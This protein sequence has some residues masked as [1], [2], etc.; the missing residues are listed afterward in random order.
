MFSKKI[1][2]FFFLLGTIVVAVSIPFSPFLLSLGQFILAGNWLAEFDFKRK[3]QVFKKRDSIIFFIS[4]FLVHLIWLLNTSNLQYALHDLK[5]KLP[6]FILPIIFGTTKALTRAEFKIILHFFLASIFVSTVYSFF[7]F[8]GITPVHATDNRNLSPFISHIRYALVITLSIY[9]L[10]SFLICNKYFKYIPSIYYIAILI[11]LV[12]FVLFLGAY[13]GSV[14]LCVIAPFALFFWLKNIKERKKKKLGIS[15]IISILILIFG[16]FTLSVIRYTNRNEIN[17]DSLDVYT[18]NGNKYNHFPNMKDYENHDLVWM[19]ICEKELGKEWNKLSEYKFEGVDKKGQPIK[20][21][22]FRYLTSKGFRK[23]S[24]GISHLTKKD[25]D[26]IQN[27]YSNYLF[28]N[29]LALYPRLYQIFWEIENYH[30]YGNPSGHSLTQRI[31]YV[32]NACRV[33]KRHFWFGAGT[34]D[35]DDEIKLQY[36]YDKS[37]LDEKWQLRAHNQFVTFFLTFGLTGFV[38]LLIVMFLTLKKEIDNVDFITLSF[39]LIA[40][41][42]MFNEDT[43]ETQAGVTFIAFFFSLF[44]FARS[45]SDIVNDQ[46]KS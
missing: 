30:R 29:K 21:T 15:L 25:I 23:D 41:F 33:I 31:E 14:V 10:I 44:I 34:G 11:W 19:Y 43:F 7:I 5:I 16:Y 42:S 13:T 46:I 24:V 26:M 18:A 9:I 45:K 20:G 37:V 6:L 22:I 12:L 35:V 27:G 39:L 28:Q 32:K 38:L 1:H 40:F 2:R 17:V 36:K 3:I 8:L 4:I